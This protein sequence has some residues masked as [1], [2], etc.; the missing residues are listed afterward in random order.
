MSKFRAQ[1]KKAKFGNPTP[2]P[3]SGDADKLPPIFSFEYMTDGTG[4]SVNCCDSDNRSAL[5]SKM[6][7][8]S[9]MT[10]MQIR[11]AHRHGLG[12]EKISRS[13]VTAPLPSKL[14]DEVEILAIRY[15]GKRP[16]IGFREG[17]VFNILLIDH[18]FSAYDHG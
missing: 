4:Y 15:N 18:D 1:P 8:L 6:F 14:T 16:M 13:S 3:V 10:W 9:R 2:P 5:A 11:L 17:R 12:S 7:I